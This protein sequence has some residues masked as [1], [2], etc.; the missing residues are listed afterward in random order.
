MIL[1]IEER[2]TKN[3]REN[4]LFTIQWSVIQRLIS[5]GQLQLLYWCEIHAENKLLV[6]Y[7][8]KR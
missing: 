7:L 4:S 1:A 3:I 8:D 2:L 6:Y 5:E